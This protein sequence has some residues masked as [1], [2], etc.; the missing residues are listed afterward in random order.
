MSQPF[1]SRVLSRIELLA[2]EPR[3]VQAQVLKGEEQY[4]RLREGDDRIIYSI[5]DARKEIRI[6]KI[7]HSTA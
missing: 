2:K 7:G 6:I 4:Y 5:E 3:P 1:L